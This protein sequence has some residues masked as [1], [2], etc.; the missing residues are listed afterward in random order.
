MRRWIG[1]RQTVFWILPHRRE[2]HG[3]RPPRRGRSCRGGAVGTPRMR[4]RPAAASRRLY[5][6]R[7]SSPSSRPREELGAR[8]GNARGRQ[9]RLVAESGLGD[10]SSSALAS[11]AA[12]R[13]AVHEARR[14]DARTALTRAH[15]LRPQL[16]HGIPWVTIQVGLELTRA[17]PPPPALSRRRPRSFFARDRGGC[18]SGQPAH[19]ASRPDLQPR[20]VLFTRL[21]T[22]AVRQ[23]RSCGSPTWPPT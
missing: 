17:P 12:A 5:S 1:S 4:A 20:P 10:Y 19:G 8:Q 22:G 2:I 3:P 9:K 7:R 13:V 18:L 16:D 15:R 11:A 23:V 21:L 6:R 14:Q